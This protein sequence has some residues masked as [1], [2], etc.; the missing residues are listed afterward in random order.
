MRDIIKNFIAILKVEIDDLAAD[1]NLLI[2]ECQQKK[3]QK[4]IT[5]YVYM[6]NMA[7]FR[8]ELTA[9][10][11]FRRIIEHTDPTRFSTLEDLIAYLKDAFRE[12]GY[13]RAINICVER[14]M[15]KVS[16]YVTQ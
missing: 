7:L 6:E 14:K 16:R 5:D 13:V 8:H 3:D 11:S 9:V 2:Q 10:D 4:Q 15:Q 1:I 12:G